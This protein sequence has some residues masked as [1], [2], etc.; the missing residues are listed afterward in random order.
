MWTASLP[1]ERFQWAYLDRLE[2]EA[3]WRDDETFAL[4]NSLFENSGGAT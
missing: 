2:K 3:I 4:L 1:E